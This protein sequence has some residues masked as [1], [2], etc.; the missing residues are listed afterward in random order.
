MTLGRTDTP[1]CDRL[2]QARALL[3][4]GAGGC[5]TARGSSCTCALWGTLWGGAVA[6][7]PGSEVGFQELPSSS[8]TESCFCPRLSPSLPARRDPAGGRAGCAAGC[9]KTPSPAPPDP[10]CV[11]L[12]SK[13]HLDVQL[14]TAWSPVW[15]GQTRPSPAPVVLMGPGASAG[16]HRPPKAQGR[17][18][19]LSPCPH[20]L[21]WTSSKLLQLRLPEVS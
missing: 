15:L 18:S 19:P 7:A 14:C 9:P 6:G 12:T 17:V 16:R 20:A 11:F 21:P 2:R 1:S 10:H 5:L 8:C 13:G 3:L 4:S